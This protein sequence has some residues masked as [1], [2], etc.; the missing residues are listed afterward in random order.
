MNKYSLGSPFCC[1]TEVVIPHSPIVGPL[2]SAQGDSTFGPYS[3]DP[4]GPY[5]N[6]SQESDGQ[7]MAN[8][9]PLK[10]LMVPMASQGTI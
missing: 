1:I 3:P 5:D 2:L 7:V 10:C 4:L 9:G 6:H 8:P